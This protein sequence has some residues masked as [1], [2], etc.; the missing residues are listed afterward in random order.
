[1]ETL[2]LSF[3]NIKLDRI[4]LEIVIFLYVLTMDALLL[5]VSQNTA[6]VFVCLFVCLFGAT[7][8]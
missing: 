4:K 5:R 8:V 3:S 2:V 6:K 1:L 7:G